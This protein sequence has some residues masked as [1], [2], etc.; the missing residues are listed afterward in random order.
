MIVLMVQG[1]SS[2]VINTKLYEGEKTELGIY[3][4]QIEQELLNEVVEDETAQERLSNEKR[5]LDK[6]QQMIHY[7]LKP[8]IV[9]TKLI[10]SQKITDQDFIGFFN[11]MAK[12]YNDKRQ[13]EAKQIHIQEKLVY[14]KE[15]IENIVESQKENLRLY[16]FQFAYYKLLQSNNEDAIH[17]QTQYLDESSQTLR[18]S[19]SR[20]EF[21]VSQ[22]FEQIETLERKLKEVDTKL[23]AL[24]LAKEQEL[25]FSETIS[26][27]LEQ[28]LFKSRQSKDEYLH[29]YIDQ[30]FYVGLYAYQQNSTETLMEKIET[31]RQRTKEFSKEDDL[32]R[33]KYLL[34]KKFSTQELDPMEYFVVM[35]REQ[36]ANLSVEIQAYMKEPLFIVDEQ[37]VVIRNIIEAFGI[38]L[39]GL[40]IGR[41]Y[42]RQ[43]IKRHLRRKD[44]SEISSKVMA[45]AGMTVILILS[46]LLSITRLG[47]S[48]SHLAVIAGALSIGIG[49][50]LRSVVSN[51]MAGILILSE[52][53][54][55]LGHYIS[56]DGKQAG[57]VV[58]I[59]LRATTLRTIDNTHY[60]IPNSDLIDKEVLNLTLEDRIRRIYIPFKVAYG[61]DLD[62]IKKIV[63]KAVNESS[64]KILRDV[65]GKKPTIWMRNMGESFIELD[66]LVWVEGYRPSIKSSLLILI[67]KT[68]LANGIELPNPQ[69]D[70]HLKKDKNK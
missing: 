57:K 19:V 6:L 63:L 44:I 9:D 43:F 4:T 13:I 28:R 40:I 2:A 69:L 37:P 34:L 11:Q 47:L 65:Y 12:V 54:V 49:F 70:I 60:I 27:A 56:I 66:L 64:V 52:K 50:A 25:L 32:Y 3:Y 61:S 14:L 39:I 15:R 58:D 5:L 33:S 10:E 68:L 31:I 8:L 41:L 35:V 24:N 38:I 1:L 67:H 45:N 7:Q 46:F 62:R 29:N 42:H 18:M 55:K 22:A 59:G 48:L 16:Q 21:H 17:N 36:F 20:V 30:L 26:P 53:N 51:Y 23:V